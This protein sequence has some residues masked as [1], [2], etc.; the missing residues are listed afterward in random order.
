MGR[1][2]KYTAAS[3][4][5][6]VAAYFKSI[7]YERAVVYNEVYEGDDGTARFRDVI[8]YDDEGKPIMRKVWTKPPSLAGLCLFLHIH[9]DTW[10]E[11]GKDEKMKPIVQEARMIVEDYWNEQLANDCKGARFALEAN[12]G[13]GERWTTKQE[14]VQTNVGATLEEFLKQQEREADA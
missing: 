6:G 10:A 3:L 11:Y 12:M 1:P 2:K 5:K 13:W 7:R 9:R 4:K 8:A 14:V